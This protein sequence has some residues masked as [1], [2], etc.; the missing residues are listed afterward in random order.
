MGMYAATSQATSDSSV[1]VI[2]I[3]WGEWIDETLAP[4]RMSA[5]FF[6]DVIDLF[7]KIGMILG[8]DRI[9]LDVPEGVALTH[10]N[11]MAHNVSLFEKKV[12]EI[13]KELMNETVSLASKRFFLKG[14]LDSRG[15]ISQNGDLVVS[16]PASMEG[17]VSEIISV[18]IS[19]KFTLSDTLTKEELLS[20]GRGSW[21]LMASKVARLARNACC[22]IK[23]DAFHFQIP[24][25][26]R[27]KRSPPQ[28]KYQ[29]YPSRDEMYV[30]G[31][32][33]G[34]G[35]ASLAVDGQS[36]LLRAYLKFNKNRIWDVRGDNIRRRGEPGPEI[37][38]YALPD[39][40]K[41]TSLFQSVFQLPV[42]PERLDIDEQGTFRK[43]EIVWTIG[44]LY[45]K[46]GIISR[47]FPSKPVNQDILKYPPKY[48]MDIN[49]PKELAKAFL[50]GISDATA[51]I[52]GQESAAFGSTGRPR[53]Q[54]E[55]DNER[56]HWL[57]PMC[58]LFQRVMKVPVLNNNVPHPTIKCR[59]KPTSCLEHNHQFRACAFYFREVNFQFAVKKIAYERMFE[60]NEI[61]D[62]KRRVFCPDNRRKYKIVDEDYYRTRYAQNRI[63]GMTTE[64]FKCTQHEENFEKLPPE[65]RGKHYSEFRLVCRDLG[66]PYVKDIL[67]SL[68]K[69]SLY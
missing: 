1:N 40:L 34:K 39:V 9:S 31:F 24:L 53:I 18:L 19:K 5:T 13:F 47:L 22:V 30:L 25:R 27:I 49:M 3:A 26:Q 37:I 61:P 62:P 67:P 65:I 4:R 21:P 8:R 36:I 42:V 69:L 12:D 44:P 57:V 16:V 2:P 45:S 41:L 14:I 38:E 51:V 58:F 11:I 17:S 20:I 50:Q 32:I 15:A 56:W 28:S 55:P 7:L 48:L 29:S 60:R 33:A 68:S 35:T 6:N 64:P 43:K 23:K 52:P 63:A 59:R 54:L 10:I 66:C 46:S